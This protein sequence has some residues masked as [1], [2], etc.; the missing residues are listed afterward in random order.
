[1]L[2][3]IVEKINIKLIEEAEQIRLL[4]NI[5]RKRQ[6]ASICNTT[7]RGKFRTHCRYR[8]AGRQSRQRETERTNDGQS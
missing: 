7:S 5:I 3:Q 6:A 8:K 4:V 2:P 1:M